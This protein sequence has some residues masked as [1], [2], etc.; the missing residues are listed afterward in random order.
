MNKSAIL[1]IPMSQYAFAEAE[2]VFTIRLRTAKGDLDSCTLY[3]GDRACMQSPVVF[4]KTVMERKWQDT[5]FDY[6]EKTISDAP[7]RLCY[8]FELSKGE[9]RIYYYG[10]DF[11]SELPDMV[12]EDGFV[13][14][15]R[16]EYYQYPYAMRDE[17]INE[18]EWFLRAVVYNIFPDSFASD[19]HYI[20]HKAIGVQNSDGQYCYSKQ[21]GTIE[22]IRKNLDYIQEMGFDCIYLNPVFMAG[23]YHKY[24][25]LD[26][27]EIDPCMGS[28]EEFRALVDEI[29]ARDMHIIIDGVFNHCSWYFPYFDDVVKKGEKSEYVE[30]FYD[31]KFPVIRPSEGKMPEYACFAYEPKMPKLNTANPKVQDYFAQVGRYWIEEFHVDG[32][33]LDVAN[34]ID[35]NFWRKF[36][37]AV[38][39]ANPEAVLI[40]E[41]WE[42]SETW[43]R[44][45]AFDSTMNYDFRKHCRSYFALEKC[46]A[47]EFAGAMTDMFLRY[48]TQVSLAQLNLLDSHDVARFLSLCGGNR[49]KWMAAFAYLCFA[50][51]VPSVFYGDE[52]GI[53]GIKEP[54]YRSPMLWEK[55]EEELENFVKK[56]IRIRKDWIEPRDTWSVFFADDEK[57]FL[58]F[59]RSGSHT[60]RLL[61]HRGE[62]F[63]DTQTYCKGGNVLLSTETVGGQLGRYGVQIILSE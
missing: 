23:E 47:S 30:W 26:Y 35:R 49:E 56:C 46:T 11:H 1:H 41:V 13:I 59:E 29:H 6:Y 9:K 10:D 52:K 32:W 19:T 7:V 2:G 31:L 63:V 50:P 17:I 21:G 44:G 55:E 25:I 43:L 36:R 61:I 27:Y 39:S 48:P 12:M 18:P 15:G 40:G 22:G 45:D 24:D 16:S 57:D 3:Y 42:N 4:E 20:N 60:L 38:K 14:E 54:E 8:Y 5:Q 34:E 28:K 37:N 51:G 53:E 33:R 58:V 62:G